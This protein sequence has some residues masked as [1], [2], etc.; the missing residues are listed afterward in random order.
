[1]LSVAEG[2]LLPDDGIFKAEVFGG[3]LAK[4]LEE[5]T[6]NQSIPVP[7]LIGH[8]TTD[9]LI[10]LKLQKGYVASWCAAGQ[11]M[12]YREYEGRDHLT[13]VA[14]DSPMVKD[15]LQWSRDRLAGKP[16]ITNC[17]P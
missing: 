15:L 9:D 7:L 1:M 12:D 8:G 11:A 13:V 6:P 16:A 5:Q 3:A 2:K 14:A 17:H 10:S 4:R